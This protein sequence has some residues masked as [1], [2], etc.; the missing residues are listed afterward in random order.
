MRLETL[1]MWKSIPL[2]AMDGYSS[3]WSSLC[4]SVAETWLRSVIICTFLV[5]HYPY[6]TGY[7]CDESKLL[8][9]DRGAYVWLFLKATTFVCMHFPTV[10]ELKVFKG[11]IT[12]SFMFM[13]YTDMYF[14]QHQFCGKSLGMH[15]SW[16]KWRM[17]CLFVLLILLV[18]S[19]WI[20]G[21][22]SV[23]SDTLLLIVVL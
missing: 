10:K 9:V 18:L 5:C 23:M 20:R 15:W 6:L 12:H 21:N 8:S 7:P 4:S 14:S 11:F 19:V 22:W 16:P 1:N 2:A 13:H 3:S 17:L